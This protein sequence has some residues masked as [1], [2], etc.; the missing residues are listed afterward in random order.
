M[1]DTS[2]KVDDILAF[3]LA[4]APSTTKMYIANGNEVTTVADF[5]ANTY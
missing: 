1:F 2:E 4:A 5:L 3:L